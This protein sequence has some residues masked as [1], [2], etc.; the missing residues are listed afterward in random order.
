MKKL[1]FIGCA[2]FIMPLCSMQQKEHSEEPRKEK[3]RFSKEAKTVG[4]SLY[5]Q[6]MPEK[7]SE[8]NEKQSEKLSYLTKQQEQGPAILESCEHCKILCGGRVQINDLV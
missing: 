5:R 6:G 8:K 4:I 1:I 2:L 3:D 7:K